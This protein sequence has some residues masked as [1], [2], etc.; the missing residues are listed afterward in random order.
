[1]NNDLEQYAENNFTDLDLE[2]MA[3]GNNPVANAYRELLS[4]RRAAKQAKPFAYYANDA[5]YNTERAALKDGAEEVTT[6]YTTPQPP[7]TEQYVWIKCSERLPETGRKV[8]AVIDFNSE[9]VSEFVGE[10]TYTGSTFRRGFATANLSD[11]DGVIVTHWMPLPA[12]PK[13]ESN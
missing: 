10:M 2:G 3:H 11:N 12:A 6:L 8:L 9:L 13:P 1:M 5:Y 4:F 7:H